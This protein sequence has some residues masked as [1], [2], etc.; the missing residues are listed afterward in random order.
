M[1]PELLPCPFCGRAPF[2]Q[3]RE[4]AQ[5][6]TGE[7]WPERVN[8]YPCG[9]TIQEVVQNGSAVERWNRRI[10]QVRPDR[11]ITMPGAMYDKLFGK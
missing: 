8:C 11:T 7:V 1:N 9:I 3:P 4:T 6:L 10:I 2:Y 5:D